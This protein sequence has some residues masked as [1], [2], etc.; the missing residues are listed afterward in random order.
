MPDFL[1]EE[2]EMLPHPGG[3]ERVMVGIPAYNEERRIE[4]T[5]RRVLRQAVASVLVV[6]DGSTDGTASILDRLAREHPSLAVVHQAN[7]GYGS[8]HK[9][10]L[11]AFRAS[12][13]D[14]FVLLHGDGQH[15]PEEMGALLGALR[16]GADVVLGSRAL[17]DMRAG[18]M[19][20]YK[21]LGNRVLTFVE[22]GV[23]GTRISSFHCGFKACN[24]STAIAV[25]YHGRTDGF[26][27]DGAFLVAACKTGLKLA[28]VPVTTIYHPDGTSHL[29][30]MPYLLE[31]LRFMVSSPW[32]GARRLGP[33]RTHLEPRR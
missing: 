21:Y 23:F 17:G 32:S 13:A 25:P 1:R 31:I 33:G 8:T 29:R 28:Q 18:G 9:M 26:H 12:D 7:R 20:L 6:D 4:D 10:L 2:Q 3:R 30:P 15:A 22:N 5:V 27:F 14:W 11:A 19:P 16:G 24:R